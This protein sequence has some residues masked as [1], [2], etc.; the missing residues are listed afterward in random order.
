MDQSFLQNCACIYF[1]KERTAQDPV[2]LGSCVLSDV[3]FYPEGDGEYA[4]LEE[5]NESYVPL[6]VSP[7]HEV[8]ETVEAPES[9]TPQSSGESSSL[10]PQ[11]KKPRRIDP[12][13]Y[14]YVESIQEP[15]GKRRCSSTGTRRVWT[16]EEDVKLRKL[17][18]KYNQRNW[19]QI[20]RGA[21]LREWLAL[22]LGTRRPETECR[23]HYCRVL[24]RTSAVS[25][26]WGG[27][28]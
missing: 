6:T 2:G 3:I 24:E 18:A 21:C 19:K 17:V 8:K 14:D 12:D 5:G 7:P 4:F 15:H 28:G 23:Q 25:N 1:S 9:V 16:P 20:A 10:P 22:E 13:V 11:R 26:C 27:E